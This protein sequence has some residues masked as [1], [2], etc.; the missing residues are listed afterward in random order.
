MSVVASA[1]SMM[2]DFM[3]MDQVDG[4]SI[5]LE[6]NDFQYDLNF[7]DSPVVLSEDGGD[8]S[9]NMVGFE[10]I[11]FPKVFHVRCKEV[12]PYNKGPSHPT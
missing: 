10:K 4:K 12:I 7:L 8:E 11:I 3:A 9:L 6:L 2:D 5:S 1:M